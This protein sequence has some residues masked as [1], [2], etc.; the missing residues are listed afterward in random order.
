MPAIPTLRRM[1][2]EDAEFEVSLN[3]NKTLSQKKKK[4]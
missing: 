4:K 2:Q 3:N 1:R